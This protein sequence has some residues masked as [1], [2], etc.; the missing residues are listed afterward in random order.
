MPQI[1]ELY[2]I[3]ERRKAT[4][5]QP[6]DDS[7]NKYTKNTI[8]R[9]EKIHIHRCRVAGTKRSDHQ[10][11]KYKEKKLGVPKIIPPIKALKGG[12]Y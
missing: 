3:L 10:T 8:F 11:P 1:K 2:D 12:I 6:I 9:K 7:I 5:T 4:S